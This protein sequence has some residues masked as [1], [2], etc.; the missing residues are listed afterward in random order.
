MVSMRYSR[1]SLIWSAMGRCVPL[2]SPNMPACSMARRAMAPAD[3]VGDCTLSRPRT[4]EAPG[5]RQSLVAIMR[6]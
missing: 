4:R 2:R 5:R 1:M 3:Q 6:V